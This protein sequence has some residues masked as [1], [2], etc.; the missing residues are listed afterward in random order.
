MHETVHMARDKGGWRAVFG[1]DAD[2]ILEQIKR[3]IKDGTKDEWVQA[4][5]QARNAETPKEDLLEETISYF[6]QNR[7]NAKTGIFQKIK[8]EIYAIKAVILIRAGKFHKRYPD[9]PYRHLH[10]KRHS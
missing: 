10:H 3:N 8:P 1:K 9:F 7:D 2:K 6:L 5:E 4:Q